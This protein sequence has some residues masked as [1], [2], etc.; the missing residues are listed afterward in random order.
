MTPPASPAP[1]QPDGEA[2]LAEPATAPAGEHGRPGAADASPVRPGV[3]HTTHGRP[4]VALR[5]TLL[6]APG[7]PADA[8]NDAAIGELRLE[9]LL[10]AEVRAPDQPPA[11]EA[12]PQAPPADAPAERRRLSATLTGL[13]IAGFKSFAEP[14]RVPV[15]PGLTGIVGPNGCGKSNVVEALRWAMGESSAKSLRGGEMDDIIFAGTATRPARSLGEV[16]LSLED[17]EGV[18]PHPHDKAAEIRLRLA[19]LELGLVL[20]GAQPGDAGGLLQHRAAFLRLRLDQRGDAALADHGGGPGAGA[21]V[22]EHGLHVAGADLP[23]VDA[24]GAALAAGDA[25]D[26]LDV[27]AV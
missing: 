1:R 22:H 25:A 15:L 24:E 7:E 10:P 26:D 20:A 4:G 8:G 12:A 23:P 16:I 5:G 6:T 27:G 21:D 17:A 3:A 2:P 19:Q 13:R 14:V 9:A 18:A 11:T